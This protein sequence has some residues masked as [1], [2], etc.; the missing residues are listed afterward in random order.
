MR[1]PSSAPPRPPLARRNPT[2]KLAA[3]VVVSGVVTFVLDPF[4]PAVLYALALVGVVLGTRAPARTIALAHVPFVT[5]AGGVLLVNA[6]TRPGTDLWPDGPLRVTAEGLG[7]GGALAV[8][9]LLVGVLAL[10]FVLST[11]GVDLMTS[12][13][14]DARLPARQTYAVL[15]GYRLLQDLPRQ[16]TTIRYAQ[17]VRAPRWRAGR[18]P[19]GPRDLARAAFTLLVTSVRRAERMARLEARGLGLTP[20]TTWRP[21][22]ADRADWLLLVAVVGVLAAVLLT[23]AGLGTLRGPGALAG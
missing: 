22:R 9:T 19:A 11:D 4:T 8:R 21:T 10:G 6:L 18:L 12:L 23:S 7:V 2:V 5:F 15:A 20:R 1:P 17:A 13:H 3:L 14:H 16:W